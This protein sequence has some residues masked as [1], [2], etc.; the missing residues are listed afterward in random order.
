MSFGSPDVIDFEGHDRARTPRQLSMQ[1]SKKEQMLSV[2]EK[3]YIRDHTDSKG[4]SSSLTDRD[5][6]TIAIKMRMV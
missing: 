1:I 5:E 6:N 4:S 2:D 3:Y